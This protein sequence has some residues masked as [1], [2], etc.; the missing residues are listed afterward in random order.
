MP[1]PRVLITRS[2]RQASALADQLRALGADPI[3]IP[4]IELADPTTFAPL[5]DALAHLDTF[6]WLLFTSANAVEAFH[7][8]LT[9]APSKL[10]TPDS[11]PLNLA[12]LHALKGT[13]FSPSVSQPGEQGALAPEGISLP[14][15]P[16]RRHRCRHRPSPRSRQPPRPPPPPA[17]RSRVPRRSPPPPHPPARRN[18]HPLPPPPRRN[19]PRLPPRH[20][21]RRRSRRHHRPRLPQHRPCRLHRFHPPALLLPRPMAGRHHLHQQ[22]H[23][24]KPSSITRSLRP[25]SST[26]DPRASP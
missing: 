24:D 19:R 23:S 20:P 21:P 16:H 1:A 9:E 18:P 13:G 6:H 7:C 5:D 2:P 10:A 17:S 14:P 3:L 11:L 15:P 22:L 25:E 4:A 26:G 8:R 12:G